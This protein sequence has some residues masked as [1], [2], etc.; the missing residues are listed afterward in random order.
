[1]RKIR[2]GDVEG[3]SHLPYEN[4]TEY[5]DCYISRY[6]LFVITVWDISL[7]S[8]ANGYTRSMKFHKAAQFSYLAFTGNHSKYADEVL[9]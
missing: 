3:F 8:T 4:F 7:S 2:D 6:E 1:M 9:Y 5:S